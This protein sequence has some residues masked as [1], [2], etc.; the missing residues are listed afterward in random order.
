MMMLMM[1]IYDE[2][3]D[4][5]DDDDDEWNMKQCH[6]GHS[7][8]VPGSAASGSEPSIANQTARYN[9]LHEMRSCCWQS[10]RREEH[11][12]FGCLA[13]VATCRSHD[14]HFSGRAEREERPSG[15]TEISIFVIH[16]KL[17][18]PFGD[19]ARL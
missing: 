5:V 16:Q 6:P 19:M 15:V 11:G 7:R 17:T 2:D 13:C 9:H 3:T 10:Y 14:L 12:A 4:H 1:V 18:S 8:H